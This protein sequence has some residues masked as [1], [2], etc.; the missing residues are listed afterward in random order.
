VA[1]ASEVEERNRPALRGI[2]SG[3]ASPYCDEPT[4]LAVQSGLGFSRLRRLLMSLLQHH[5]LSLYVE[6]FVVLDVPQ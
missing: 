4:W 3:T 2:V 1:R 6:R 5:L